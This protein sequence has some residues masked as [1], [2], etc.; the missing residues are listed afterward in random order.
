[1]RS[2]DDLAARVRHLWQR[3]SP[4]TS[5][6]LTALETF[7]VMAQLRLLTWVLDETLAE[8]LDETPAAAL[9]GDAP[10][11]IADAIPDETT[12]TAEDLARYAT[13]VSQP[14]LRPFGQPNLFALALPP[15]ADLLCPRPT[16][17]VFLSRLHAE[18]LRLLRIPDP[19]G[20][21]DQSASARLPVSAARA[22]S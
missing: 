9:A 2:P 22:R 21:P 13:L 17:S 12:Q 1:M 11:E 7:E 15:L 8:T 18:Q 10:S 3:L 4:T 5:Q 6:P 14:V 16:V 19:W 20:Q